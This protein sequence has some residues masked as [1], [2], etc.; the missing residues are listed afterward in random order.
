MKKLFTDLS[1]EITKIEKKTGEYVDHCR[2]VREL[3]STTFWVFVVSNVL[4]RT[5][6]SSS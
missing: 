1:E 5:L 6:P 2:A 3:L 4:C